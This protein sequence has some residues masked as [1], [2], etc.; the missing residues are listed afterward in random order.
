M[1][2]YDEIMGFMKAYFPLTVIWGSRKRRNISWTIFTL[3][4]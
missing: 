1:F 4:I 2:S 3:P